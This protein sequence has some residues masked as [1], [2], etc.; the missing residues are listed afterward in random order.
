MEGTDNGTTETCCM[1]RLHNRT[2]ETESLHE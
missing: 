2:T 1:T